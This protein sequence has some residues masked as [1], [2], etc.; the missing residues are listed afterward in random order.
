MGTTSGI[1]RQALREAA[2]RLYASAVAQARQPAFYE[3][4][5]VPDSLDGRYDLLV[6]HLW[7][8][9]RRLR[10]ETGPDARVASRL[11]QAVYD[12]FFADMDRNLR[13]MG[14]GD[15][16]VGKRV[17]A[18]ARGFYGRIAAYDA[19]LMAGDVGLRDGLRRNLFGTLSEAETP[20]PEI[21]AAMAAYVRREAEQ[22][23]RMP[24][25]DLLAG[26]LRFG[27]PPAPSG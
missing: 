20:R 22:S 19:G 24:V 15:L 8:V 10:A 23:A 17:K 21:L 9:M 5:G 2:D 26:R 14:V 18:M 27:S 12:L 16:G 4:C 6:L 3:R 7:L 1:S 25:A 11:A 13:E